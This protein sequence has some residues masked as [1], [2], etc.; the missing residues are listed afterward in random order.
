MSKEFAATVSLNPGDGDVPVNL[1]AFLT[2]NGFDSGTHLLEQLI[3]TNETATTLFYKPHSSK[4]T[5]PAK[6]TGFKLTG[7]SINLAMNRSPI[8]AARVWLY[9]SA[10]TEISVYA[11]GA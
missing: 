1:L 2:A 10:E 8:N 3:I 11:R 6:E 9:V 4:E 7:S 5:P